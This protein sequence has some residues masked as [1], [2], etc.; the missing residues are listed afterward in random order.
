MKSLSR[1]SVAAALSVVLLGLLSLLAVKHLRDARP[2]LILV[3]LDTVRYDAFWLSE[4]ARLEADPAREALQS[5][6]RFRRVQSVSPWTVPSV[7]SVMTGL[8]PVRHGAGRLEGPVKNLDETLPSRLRDDVPTLAEILTRAG[9]E[10]VNFNSHPWVDLQEFGLSRGFLDQRGGIDQE[11]LEEVFRWLIAHGNDRRQPFFLNIHFM[12]AHEWYKAPESVVRKNLV[13]LDDDWREAATQLLARITESPSEEME[14]RFA[15]YCRSI[16]TLRTRLAKLIFVLNA[17]E[18]FGNTIVVVYSDHGEEFGD[19]L[20]ES[21]GGTSDPRGHS[22]GWGHGQSLYQELLHVPV[23]AW[24]PDQLGGD[25]EIPAS[26]VDIAPTILGWMGL[27]HEAPGWDG[28]DLSSLIVNPTPG[29]EKVRPLFATSIAYGNPR[30]ALLLGNWKLIRGSDR[31][32]LFDLG[33]DPREQQ[34]LESADPKLL[35]E[36]EALLDEFESVRFDTP[37]SVPQISPRQLERLRS[38]GYVGDANQ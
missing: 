11:I 6:L 21:L 23:L 3:C 2:N 37:P 12:A 20:Q 9:Y 31:L 13:E 34:A 35:A 8:L 14:L 28:S 38:L 26:L 5:A 15:E 7:A 36:L 16:R 24:V 27:E 17:M 33:G 4:S 32:Q 22:Q 18:L 30:S 25:V 10:T 29:S 1:K 19:R